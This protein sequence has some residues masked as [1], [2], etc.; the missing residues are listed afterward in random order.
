MK[1]KT[2]LSCYYLFYPGI[3]KNGAK[4][5]KGS[6]PKLI[7]K[8]FPLFCKSEIKNAIM[9]RISLSPFIYFNIF[10]GRKTVNFF[11]LYKHLSPWLINKLCKEKFL[12]YSKHSYC[13]SPAFLSSVIALHKEYWHFKW[14]SFKEWYKKY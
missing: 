7:E 6:T 13:D 4:L 5:V 1:L 14:G 11:I 10:F 9:A 3:S 2:D 8:C 12:H